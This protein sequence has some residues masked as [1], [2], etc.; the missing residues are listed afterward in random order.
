MEAVPLSDEEQRK[1]AADLYLKLSKQNPNI[2]V[3]NDGLRDL[4]FNATAEE[5]L[6]GTEGGRQLMK[7]ILAGVYGPTP[8]ADP[9][10]DEGPFIGSSEQIVDLGHR[11]DW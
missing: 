6:A 3:L 5:I 8:F 7:C 9:E 11:S 4:S 2:H 10:P 1:Q